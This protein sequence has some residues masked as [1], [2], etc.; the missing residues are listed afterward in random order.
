MECSNLLSIPCHYYSKKLS[1]K[2][3]ISEITNS[4]SAV[5]LNSIDFQNEGIELMKNS[6]EEI[7][8][9]ALEAARRNKKEWKDKEGDELNEKFIKIF[10]SKKKFNSILYHGEIKGIIGSDFL[11][12]NKWWLI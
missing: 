3:T 4:K 1:R 12:K 5:Y 2:L 8:Q 9:L 6:T 11:K 10:P 7:E